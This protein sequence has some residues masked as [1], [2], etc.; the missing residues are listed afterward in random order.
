MDRISKLINN[1]GLSN[2]SV[3][4]HDMV[5]DE[6]AKVLKAYCSSLTCAG[7]SDKHALKKN[8][9]VSL[10]T[11]DGDGSVQFRRPFSCPDCGYALIW[12]REKP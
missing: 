6:V 3:N 11:V 4:Y 7:R 10:K 8:V 9:N 2:E 5:A 12:K 1:L